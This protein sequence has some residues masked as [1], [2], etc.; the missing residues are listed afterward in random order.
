MLLALNE[1]T[2]TCIVH[3]SRVHQRFTVDT[4]N[5]GD[6][7]LIWYWYST[8]F[9]MTMNIEANCGRPWVLAEDLG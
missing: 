8:Y 9:N 2:L 1:K 6:L 3:P 5:T 4:Y 7:V